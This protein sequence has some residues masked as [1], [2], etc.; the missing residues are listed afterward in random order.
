MD[1]GEN[2]DSCV[3]MYWASDTMNPKD[4]RELG[5]T[6]GLG[7]LDI[8]T[9]PEAEPGGMVLALS[10]PASVPPDTEFVAT[11]YVWRANKGDKIK[12]EVPSG[13]KLAGGEDDEKT[14]EDE[15]AGRKQVF[16]RLRSV[17][18]GTYELKATSGK[19]KSKPKQVVVKTTSIFG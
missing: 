10:V 11:A 18:S 9:G 16:W 6:Y 19:A 8:G 1:S 5:F 15:G 13:L 4:V 12:L 2:K 3:A 14:I 17:G 7:T